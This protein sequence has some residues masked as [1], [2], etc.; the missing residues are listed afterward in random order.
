[1]QRLLSLALLRR[2]PLVF[3]G[4]F[5]DPTLLVGAFHRRFVEPLLT[6]EDRIAG[7]LEFLR[8]MK[9]TRLDEFATL[10]RRLKMPTLFV[11][12]A[13]DPT[14][15]EPRAREMATQLPNVAG[16]HTIPG[17]KLFVQEERPAE[18]ARL[19]GTFLTSP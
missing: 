12:G 9:F 19:I 11:W 3:G 5:D 8:R 10:H 6:Q 18:V 16:F 14:F 2:S 13:N 4:C 7:A 17:A 1:M 15:P